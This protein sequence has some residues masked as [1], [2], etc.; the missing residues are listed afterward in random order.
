ME[1]IK[2][3][4]KVSGKPDENGPLERPTPRWKDNKRKINRV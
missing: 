3:A 2:Y 1:E 4:D